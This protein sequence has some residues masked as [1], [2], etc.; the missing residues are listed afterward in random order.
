MISPYRLSCGHTFGITCIK[1]WKNKECP[2]CR[3]KYDL[4][5]P[6]LELKEKIAGYMGSCK[7]CQASLLAVHINKHLMECETFLS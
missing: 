4:L 1:Q 7:F 3:Q 6:Q 5:M 2:L